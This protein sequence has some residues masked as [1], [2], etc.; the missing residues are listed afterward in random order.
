MMYLGFRRKKSCSGQKTRFL[1]PA[2]REGNVFTS[3]SFLLSTGLGGGG[4]PRGGLHWGGGWFLHPGG[5]V[6]PGGSASRG[7]GGMHPG[8]GVFIQEGGSTSRKGGLHPEG[9]WADPPIGY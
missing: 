1:P 9:G 7:E 5:S 3:V 6:Y 4:L 8:R 2:I